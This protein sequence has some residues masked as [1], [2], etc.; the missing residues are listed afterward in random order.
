MSSQII[1]IIIIIRRHRWQAISHI[2]IDVAYPIAKLLWPLL[3]NT[4]V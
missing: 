2:A 1:I 4:V 3:C